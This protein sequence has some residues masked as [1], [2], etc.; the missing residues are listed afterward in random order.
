MD[1]SVPTYLG[2][3]RDSPFPD[4]SHIRCL[5]KILRIRRSSVYLLCEAQHE[6]FQ[7]RCF[8][9]TNKGDRCILFR[10]LGLDS[11]FSPT[12]PHLI[13][14]CC[15]SPPLPS[16]QDRSNNLG[17]AYSILILIPC[18]HTDVIRLA[19]RGITIQRLPSHKCYHASDPH[20]LSCAIVC[21]DGAASSAR[22]GSPQ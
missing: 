11:Y 19:W 15:L 21:Y 4:P 17:A 8:R 13:I 12:I 3:R 20:L 7:Q 14:H 22:R 10:R 6:A 5:D 18:T 16:C 9:D 1:R 2:F